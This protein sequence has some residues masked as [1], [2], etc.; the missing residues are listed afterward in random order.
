MPIK[1]IRQDI[2]KM[3]VDAIVNTTNKDKIG[4]SGV[5]LAVHTLAGAGLDA[6][7][8][9]LPPLELGQAQI[10]GGYNLP[11]KY[12]IH[13]RGPIW[14]GGAEGESDALRSCYI[15]SLKLAVK[16]RCRSVAFP[17]ISSGVYGFP[18]DQVLKFAVQ[19]ITEFLFEHELCVYICVFDRESYS[20]SQKLFSDI[21]AFIDDEYI[22]EHNDD[23]YDCC[24]EEMRETAPLKMNRSIE[25][26]KAMA[27]I[28]ASLRD[29]LKNRDKGFKEMLFDMI[30]KSGMDDVEVYKKANVDKRTFS[31][32]K[33]NKNY[34][35]SK[36][37]AI[38]FAIS[39][40]LSLDDTQALLATLGF[41][42]SSSTVFDVIVRYFI[43]KGNYNIF[44]INEALFEFDQKP[45][46]TF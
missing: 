25:C 9:S 39:L 16:R 26:Q 6:E 40:C 5:D 45:L 23:Y 36:S 12:V 24:C 27:P 15:E 29:Q 37:T 38:A 43:Q 18:K 20:F 17:L 32:I 30:D 35:P 34:K 3:T 31:K 1:I 46:G 41:T 28:D 13:T 7:C 2:T 44:E 19:T 22:D 14:N 4:Y 11:C 8:A 42:L 10:T 33:S 21:Q